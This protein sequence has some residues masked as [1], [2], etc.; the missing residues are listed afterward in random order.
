MSQQ[1]YD[2]LGVSRDATVDEI[3]KAYKKAALTHHPDKGGDSE[4]FKECGAAVETLSDDR[5]RAAYDAALLRTRSRDG[6]NADRNRS[7]SVSAPS[8]AQRPPAQQSSSSMPPKPPRPP[9]PTGG[10]VE[11][12]S[13]P[14]ALSI[15][16]LKELLSAL[17]LDHSTCLDKA[18]LLE[19]LKERKDRRGSDSNPQGPASSRPPT[20]PRETPKPAPGAPPPPAQPGQ[21][22]IRVKVMSL[23]CSA[24]GKSTLI[25]RYCEGRFVQKYIPTIGIDYGV[26]PCKVNGHEL[27]VNFFD[28]SGGEEFKDI[29]TEF[30]G[31][32]QTNAVI[33]VYD[34]TS[35]KSF[36]DLEFWLEEANRLN[37]PLS[38]LQK[39]GGNQTPPAVA[40][41]A[42]K[43]DLP[44]RQVSR[45]D[46]EDFAYK[47]GLRYFETSASNGDAVMDAMT[48]LFEQVVSHHIE[49]GKKVAMA[50]G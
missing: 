18:D 11:I 36:A 45:G 38:K 33:L 41:C 2:L 50:S 12:P 31:M 40:L 6:L 37:C 42:N 22:A 47:H 44:K 21:R 35:R 30:Y 26:K 19:L 24:V 39:S 9:A 43:I 46:G 5:K 48:Y 29:R 25:K 28:T 14:S 10:A 3:K 4:K 13:D 16:E 17:G 49:L 20:T 8:A 34:V 15:K 1:Y 7:G 32:G 23:G 27:K